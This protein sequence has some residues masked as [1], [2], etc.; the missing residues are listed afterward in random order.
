VQ[1]S[2]PELHQQLPVDPQKAPQRAFSPTGPTLA[3]ND[4][5]PPGAAL[6]CPITLDLMCDPVMDANGYTYERIAIERSHANRPGIC[7]MTNE[8]YLYAGARLIPNR[9]VR[10]MIDAFNAGEA[11]FTHLRFERSIAT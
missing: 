2:H 8:R 11:A 3:H 10:D 6:V 4:H 7:P 9:S 5:P 1:N